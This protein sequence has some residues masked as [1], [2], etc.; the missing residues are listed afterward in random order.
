ILEARRNGPQALDTLAKN[1]A[2]SA[3]EDARL[4]LRRWGDTTEATIA[5]SRALVAA[6]VGD[7]PWI[8][9][10]ARERALGV[11]LLYRGHLREALRHLEHNPESLPIDLLEAALRGVPW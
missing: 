5:I 2:P 1:A 3:L 10:D 4:A 9:P 6:P 11:S 7:A 8:S